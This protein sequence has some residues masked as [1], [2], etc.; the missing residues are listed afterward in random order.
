MYKHLSNLPNSSS[1]KL[2]LPYTVLL[3]CTSISTDLTLHAITRTNLDKHT[4]Q[5]ISHIHFAHHGSCFPLMT[6]CF[7]LFS[8]FF[9]SFSLLFFLLYFVL[10]PFMS[11]LRDILK[12][13]EQNLITNSRPRL[14]IILSTALK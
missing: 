11:H 3:N 4:S 2:C 5:S 9:S 12:R 8:F 10:H 13:G 14:H 6:F 7:F 1:I